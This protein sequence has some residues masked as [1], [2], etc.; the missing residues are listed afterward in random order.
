MQRSLLLS[1]L[2][3]WLLFMINACDLIAQDADLVRIKYGGEKQVVDLGV[4][5]YGW[6]L[7][8]DCDGDGDLDLF[9]VCP[10][11]P[12]NGTYLFENSGAVD[13]TR[14]A[15]PIFEPA[16]RLNK[17]ISYPQQSLLGTST[18]VMTPEKVYPDFLNSQFEKPVPVGITTGSFYQGKIRNNLWKQADLDGDGLGDLVIGIG[19]WIEYGWDNAYDET[20]KWKNGPLHGYVYWAKNRGTA[21]EPKFDKPTRLLAGGKE[22]D[23][24]EMPSPCFEDFDGDGDLDLICGEFLDRFTYFEN[25]GTS[26]ELKLE[27]GRRLVDVAGVELRMDLQMIMPTSIDWDRD[28]FVDLLVGDE[29]GRVAFLRNS[30]IVRDSM[31]RFEKPYYLQQFGDEVKF[32]ALA[33]PY[34]F[35]WDGDGDEDILSGN[36]AGQIAWIENLTGTEQPQWAKPRLL[37]VDGEP[38]RIEA[39]ENGSIQGPCEAK[40]GYTCLNVADWDHDG[41]P[42][43]V[44]NTIWGKIE[45]FKNIGTRTEPKLAPRESLRIDWGGRPQKPA[46]NW[47]NPQEA[48][49]VSQWRTTPVVIDWDRDGLNDLVM[50]DHEGYLALYRRKRDDGGNLLLSPGERIFYGKG[51]SSFDSHN[52]VSDE[53]PGQLRLNDKE[54]G[55]SGR[56]KICFADW[57]GDGHLDL[58]VNSQNAS[59]LYGEPGGDGKY[60]FGKPELMA[61]R[62]LAG[63]STS[64]AVVDWN[65]DQVPDLLIG[66]EDGFFYYLPNNVSR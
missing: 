38:I 4:G 49:M 62:T 52:N 1:T 12:Y 8:Q 43:I 42:D 11:V 6:P 29:D 26:K 28:G 37:S 31:P 24:Y 36:T 63:H 21:S 9:V 66:A 45:W 55:K 40:W 65:R 19:D 32:G 51:P 16:I 53:K 50:L 5:L 64:P 56:R 58:I 61:K 23:V 35:D 14:P 47:W 46:W 57:N 10:D 34:S 3:L 13:P 20:G 15:L 27:A 44:I 22:I 30:G 25:V 41:L 17:G 7:P 33:T 18:I 2:A 54:A 48:E 59:V 39:G 60:Y